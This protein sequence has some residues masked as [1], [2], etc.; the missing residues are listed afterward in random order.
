MKH[1]LPRVAW[2]VARNKVRVTLG[3]PI[4]LAD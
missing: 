2:W 3:L 1:N 4:D